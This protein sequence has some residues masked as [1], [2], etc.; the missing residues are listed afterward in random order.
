MSGLGLSG[1]LQDF[2]LQWR[3]A[4]DMDNYH[5]DD[6]QNAQ[7]KSGYKT[8]NQNHHGYRGGLTWLDLSGNQL[9]GTIPLSLSNS[10]PQLASLNLSGNK[11]VGTIPTELASLANLQIL[12]LGNN[13]LEGS[14]TKR[15]GTT[16]S[17]L[18]FLTLSHNILEGPIPGP[19]YQL[20]NLQQLHLNGNFL[21]GSH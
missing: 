2:L 8:A 10:M 11:F 7:N 14:M 16:L 18:E 3:V 21:S 19:L 13:N 1:Q 15:I 20:S 6:D 12:H 9:T 17:N 5:G 4:N